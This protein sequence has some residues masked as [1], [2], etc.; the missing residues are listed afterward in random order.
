MVASLLVGGQARTAKGR[1][2]HPKA[3]RDTTCVLSVVLKCVN[4][5]VYRKLFDKQCAGSFWLRISGMML[6]LDRYSSSTKATSDGKYADSGES[7]AGPEDPFIC[8]NGGIIH[9]T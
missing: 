7:D 3:A 2:R 9:R 4:G 1:D 8:H 5:A 6:Y